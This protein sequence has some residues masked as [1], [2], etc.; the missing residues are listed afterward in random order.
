MTDNPLADLRLRESIDLRNRIE[1]VNKE[2]LPELTERIEACRDPD[3]EP[4][5]PDDDAQ[6]LEATKK[7]LEGQ[8]TACE[9]VV[10][11]FD[12]DPVFTLQE[13][14]TAETALLTDDVTQE[15]VNVD[16]ERQQASGAP[17]QGYHKV[18]TLELALVDAPEGMP[19]THDGEL[20]RDIYRVGDLPDHVTDYL[21]Q[22]A[23]SLNDAQTVEGVG[24][25]SDY[26]VTS[27]D[28]SPD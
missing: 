11:A 5:H 12:G 27:I 25:L 7:T 18:R 10:E 20:G 23:T 3:E 28:T 19:T 14:M 4:L 13:L 16:Y 17:K 26:G 21:Y 1:T 6:D 15:S 9:R 8:A 24:N 22:C 2:L